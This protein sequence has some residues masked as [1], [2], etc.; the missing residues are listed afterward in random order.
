[1]ATTKL[2]HL[3]RLR[4]TLVDLM[5]YCVKDGDD[6]QKYNDLLDRVIELQTEEMRKLGY[7]RVCLVNEV[8][9][10]E[11]LFI[12]TAENCDTY[13]SILLEDNPEM[14]GY[15]KIDYIR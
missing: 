9:A 10:E 6:W 11:T 1:M 8:K 4:N 13:A 12:S 7:M 2:D 3:K 15:I 14:R 5:T